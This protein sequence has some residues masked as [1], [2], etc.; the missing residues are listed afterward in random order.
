MG[1]H[2]LAATGAHRWRGAGAPL[3]GEPRWGMDARSMSEPA[4]SPELTPSTG[5]QPVPED[6]LAGAELLSDALRSEMRAAAGTFGEPGP[7]SPEPEPLA[8]EEFLL[9]SPVVAP[10]PETA[11]VPEQKTEPVPATTAELPR[12]IFVEQPPQTSSEP[13]ALPVAE[14]FLQIAAEQPTTVPVPVTAPAPW[15]VKAIAASARGEPMLDVP[16]FPVL[17]R[18]AQLMVPPPEEETEPQLEAEDSEQRSTGF[19]PV[20]PP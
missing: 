2:K 4:P 7:R 9:T 10:K 1:R 17:T 5:P 15:S 3:A 19:Q 16:A 18:M 14:S 8:R 12:E 6:P 20:E 11:P 13:A